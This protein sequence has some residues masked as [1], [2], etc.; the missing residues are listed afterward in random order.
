LAG[1]IHLR[2][3]LIDVEGTP[4]NVDT[5]QG[6]DGFVGVTFR[7][8]HESETARTA[9]I[10]IRRYVDTFHTSIRFEE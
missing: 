5:V 6:T 10:P 8:L 2:P 3:R 1:A 4:A 7:H 9:C